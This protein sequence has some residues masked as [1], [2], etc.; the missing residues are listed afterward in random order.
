ME[1]NWAEEN[2]QVFRTLMERAALY[3]RAL[4]PTMLSTGIIGVLA[5]FGGTMLKIE[6]VGGFLCY[7]S[8]VAAVVILLAVRIVRGQ[9]VKANEPIWSPPAKRVALAFSAPLFAGAGLTV[10]LMRVA[11]KMSFVDL[12]GQVPLVTFIGLWLVLYGC[13]LH[14]ASFF[15]SRGVRLLGWAFIL[16]GCSLFSRLYFSSIHDFGEENYPWWLRPHFVMGLTFGGLHL[17]AGIYLYFTEKGR[18]VQ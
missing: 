13:A 6:S 18:N 11:F 8:V 12:S 16:I 2:L 5:A 15:I 1:P 4:A 7:W 10:P 3:R 14:A 9:A 17:I